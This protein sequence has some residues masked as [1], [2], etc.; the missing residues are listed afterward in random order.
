ME[1]L[2]NRLLTCLVE[3]APNAITSAS[4]AGLLHEPD[5]LRLQSELESMEKD[6]LLVSRPNVRYRD[7][8]LPSYEGLP[9]REY[10]DVNGVKVPRLLS[11]DR[12]RPEELNIF[13][14][15]LARRM[16]QIE[17]EAER[18]IDKKLQTYWANVITMFGA[19]IGVFSLP[20]CQ[21][22]LL[23]LPLIV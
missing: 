21:N 11:D 17:A 19:F 2:R 10:M 18:K 12:P 1:S 8:L 15:T 6:G 4:L 14:E 7:Y 5:A 22:D 20:P 9:F 16:M 13:V 23:H 3:R